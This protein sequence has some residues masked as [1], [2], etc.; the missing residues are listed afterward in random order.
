MEFSE[1]REKVL[2]DIAIYHDYGYACCIAPSYLGEPH[3]ARWLLDI[4]GMETRAFWGIY[5]RGTRII[6]LVIMPPEAEEHGENCLLKNDGNSEHLSKRCTW[7]RYPFWKF[8]L[9]DGKVMQHEVR[10][11]QNANDTF[12]DL[13]GNSIFPDVGWPHVLVEEEECI[14]LCDGAQALE[15]LEWYIQH[16]THTDP[17]ECPLKFPT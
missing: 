10:L 9:E 17:N 16:S 4:D 6:V 8:T 7:I 1:I 11:I 12:G 13:L 5:F 14:L 3:L 15:K 2:A